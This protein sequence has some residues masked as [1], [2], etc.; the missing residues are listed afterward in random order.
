MSSLPVTVGEA[1][2]TKLI[3]LL[4]VFLKTILD[5][6]LVGPAFGLLVMSV[7]GLKPGWFLLLGCFVAQWIPYIHLLVTSMGAGPLN[8]QA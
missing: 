2:R 5:S 6:N 1:M 7:L 4:F 3:K 8:F